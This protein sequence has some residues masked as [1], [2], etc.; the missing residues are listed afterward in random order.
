MPLKYPC[1]RYNIHLATLVIITLCTMMMSQSGDITPSIST[2]MDWWSSCQ[3]STTALMQCKL[4]PTYPTVESSCRL[5]IVV[6]AIEVNRGQF[7][8]KWVSPHSHHFNGSMGL[9]PNFFVPRLTGLPPPWVFSLL[10]WKYFLGKLFVAFQKGASWYPFFCWFI[11]SCFS[12]FQPL[13]NYD[14]CLYWS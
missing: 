7:L 13:G 4:L 6:L 1:N 12:S 11:R 3:Q 9:S 5:W 8:L 2:T 14:H 10:E